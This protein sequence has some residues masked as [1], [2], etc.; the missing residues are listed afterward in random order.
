[1]IGIVDVE[2]QAA[3]PQMPLTPMYAFK[4]SPSSLRVR[5]VPKKIG[6]WKLTGVRLHAEYP[7]GTAHDAE[8]VLAGGVYV[9]TLSAC[10]S[11]GTTT[12]GLAVLADGVD[13]HG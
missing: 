7:D 10:I 2:I 11:P 4:D 12:E 6:P 5:N 1:M 8:C 13:E 3:R 9:G